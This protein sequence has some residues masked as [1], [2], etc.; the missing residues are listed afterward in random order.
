MNRD[1]LYRRITVIACILCL[2]C[3]FLPLLDIDLKVASDL[4]ARVFKKPEFT[5]DR[6][7][8]TI[9]SALAKLTEVSKKVKPYM[10]IITLCAFLPYL[11]DLVI[12]AL[13]F[14][15]KRA[16]VIVSAAL[17]AVSAVWI[18][19]MHVLIAPEKIRFYA[20]KK[21]EESVAGL[22]ANL[23]TENVPDNAAKHLSLLY[24]AG[25]SWGFYLPLIL[26]SCLAV[27][28]LVR[29][30]SEKEPGGGC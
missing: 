23:I 9:F 8:W 28:S 25:L 19:V 12:L 11:L 16:A 5:L 3:I 10:W 17:A 15:K 2:V 14:V 29:C 21:I 24:K 7:K 1:I 20:A 18:F 30:I 4:V 22:I 27:L 13:A 26:M 6:E